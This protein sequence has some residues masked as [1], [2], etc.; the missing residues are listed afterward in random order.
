MTQLNCHVCK[1]S[2]LPRFAIKSLHPFMEKNLARV[3]IA[4]FCSF[5]MRIRSSKKLL[6][7]RQRNAVSSKP[8][9][10]ILGY[11][12]QNRRIASYHQYPRIYKVLS[13]LVPQDSRSVNPL[14]RQLP[15]SSILIPK[16][17]HTKLKILLITPEEGCKLTLYP[18]TAF[19]LRSKCRSTD[20][21]LS[22][23]IPLVSR[24]KVLRE[25]RILI[26]QP[27]RIHQTQMTRP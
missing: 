22:P 7:W 4:R 5:V 23:V 2:K 17:W 24:L 16:Q 8:M 18:P 6:N 9:N 21:R 12:G 3:K 20:R 19:R 25:A 26:S 15:R 1:D 14:D 10:T 13:M 11:M 27:L